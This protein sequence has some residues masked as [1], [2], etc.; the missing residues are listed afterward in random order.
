M[1]S[2]G[3][4]ILIALLSAALAIAGYRFFDNRQSIVFTGEED[5]TLDLTSRPSAAV[6]SAG[7]PDFVR[8]AAKVTPAV[9]HINTQYT[10]SVASGNPF[11]GNQAVPA[12]GSGSGVIIS[13]EGYVVTNNHVI[14]NASAIE[15]VLPDKR[16]FKAKLIGRDPDTDLALLKV[17]SSDLPV[18]PLGNSDSVQVGE[19]VLAVGYPFSLNSTVTAGIISAK[20]RS[21]G[22]LNRQSQEYYSD[23]TQPGFNTA[24]ESFIQTDAA[25]N[26]GNSGGALVNS[27]GKLIGINAA[28]AS[29]TGSY[30]GYGFAIPVNLM[31]KIVNDFRKYGE[32]RR[33]YLGVNFP[34]PAV[35]DEV[36]RQ[37]GVNPAS[38][39]GVYI[40]GIQPGSGA[41]AAGLKEGDI[42]QSIDGV[43]VI[44]SS[45][46]SERIARYNPGDKV[47]LSF[48]R[49]GRS[50]SADVVLKGEEE[51]RGTRDASAESSLQ[52]K[53]GASFAPVPDRI[54]QQYRLR[55]GV[56]V[57][58]VQRGGFFDVAGIP[59][60]TIITSI[61]GMPVNSTSDMDKAIAASRSNMVR[62]V[63]ITPDGAGF[64]FSIPLGA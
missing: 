9:V 5:R 47:Q 37:R 19:W 62:V 20:G 39:K 41:A 50:R 59:E 7:N 4:V 30:A 46:L 36:L 28:I 48:L 38:V 6:S 15:V 21:I 53:L 49:D 45:E 25:I 12:R 27:D 44:S 13:P 43:R 61:N 57:T 35:E 58:G 29:Q 24:I 52:A 16:T 56:Y 60:G 31:R 14:E 2:A 64:V 63:G 32:V 17:E 10:A 33:G 34:S 40:M 18:V 8:A 22:I 1:K 42:I 51:A 55:S 23:P 26:P 3:L 11:F 54:K